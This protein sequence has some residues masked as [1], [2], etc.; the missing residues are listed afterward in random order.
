VNFLRSDE[1]SKNS[2]IVKNPVTSEDR[3]TLVGSKIRA[4]AKLDGGEQSQKADLAILWK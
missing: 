4:V 3:F 2:L 1:K